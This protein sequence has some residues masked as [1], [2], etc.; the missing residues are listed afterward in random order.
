MPTSDA[1]DTNLLRSNKAGSK[2]AETAITDPA[3]AAAVRRKR[4]LKNLAYAVFFFW[5]LV[6]FTL[7]KIPDS[8]VTNL[9]LNTL[10][11]NTPYQWQA[12][13]IGIGFFPAPHLQMDKLVL[14]PK[15]PGAGPA[16]QIDDVRIYPNPF[17]LIPTGG[18]SAFGGY[19]RAEAYKAEVK[20]SFSMGKDL[21][22]RVYT[23]DTVDL[24]KIAPLAASVALKGSL[25]SL[26]LRLNM[27]GQR[28]S[29][30]DGEITLT[31]RNVQFDP[32]NLGLQVTLPALSVGDVNLEGTLARGQLKI[33][34]FKVGG[35]GKDLDLMIP[36][37]TVN[38]SDITSA[39]HYD[40]HV[41]LKPSAALEKAVPGFGDTIGVFATKKPDGY[42]A[43][44]LTG[45][46]A[47]PGFPVRD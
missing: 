13:R 33:T 44:H 18:G 27:P 4:I 45:S 46:L 28:L 2:A 21:Y 39:T 11:Q 34:K 26:D 9:L 29:N 35:A 41:Q 1:L 47:S 17:S 3:A 23:P 37:G 40:L 20:G 22:L 24:G 6:T 36:N 14:D 43:T 30:S 25:Q 10:N 7:L 42:F 32:S 19:F 16:L 5:A 15:Y 31:A 38:L 12:E 8:L